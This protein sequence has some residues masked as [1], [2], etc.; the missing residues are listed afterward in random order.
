MKVS[1]WICHLS[2][3]SLIHGKNI[4]YA[5]QMP[6]SVL[7]KQKQIKYSLLLG[8]T[9]GLYQQDLAAQLQSSYGNRLY[10]KECVVHTSDLL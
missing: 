7:E 3:C 6:L 5:I 9:L 8:P 1:C 2:I 4:L 10:Q